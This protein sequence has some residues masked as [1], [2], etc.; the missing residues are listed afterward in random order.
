M[1]VD[2]FIKRVLQIIPTLIGLS[3][4]IFLISRVLPGDP[5]RVALG[6]EATAEQVEQLRHEMRLDQP[7]HMQYYYYVRDLIKGQFGRSLT[8]HRDVGKDLKDRFPA[9]FELTTLAMVFATLAGMLLGIT[10]AVKKDGLADQLSRVIALAGVA[11]P[12]FWLGILLQLVFAYYLGLLPTIGRGPA[13]PE[14]ITGLYLLD[15]LLTWNLKAFLIS[16]KHIALPAFTLSLSTLAQVMRLTRANMIDQMRRD[17]ILAARSYGLPEKL[18]TY[19]YMLK[20]AFTSTLTI[21]GL[22]YGFLLGNAF[23]V[24]TVFAWPGMAQYGVQAVINKDFN[25]VV[26]V[27]MVIGAAYMLINLVV[28]VL[29]GYLDPRIRYGGE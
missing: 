25:A 24:E 6:V 4:V 11:L 23:L 28:D 2:F 18:I 14:Q 10:A 21:I 5:A 13:P 16:L 12:R 20:N 27:T 7:L 15:S 26:A 9:T 8:T 29:Y 17:Y 3:I 1:P 19:K 22:T